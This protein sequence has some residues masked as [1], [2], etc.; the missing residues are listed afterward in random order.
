MS[1]ACSGQPPGKADGVTPVYRHPVIYAEGSD[2]ALQCLERRGIQLHEG[3]RAGSAGQGFQTE[4]PAAG[5]QIEH[6]RAVQRLAQDAH[7]GFAHPVGSG[8][9]PL[10]LRHQQPSPAELSADDTH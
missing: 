1:K 4:R 2:I 7:P 5:E 3:G 9:D 10:V 8:P 6:P